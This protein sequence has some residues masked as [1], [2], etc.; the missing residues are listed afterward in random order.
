MERLWVFNPHIQSSILCNKKKNNQP[1]LYH[2]YP[3]L[4]T[5]LCSLSLPP[6]QPTYSIMS[7]LSILLFVIAS[8]TCSFVL[9][10]S[11]LSTFPSLTISFNQ[12]TSILNPFPTTFVSE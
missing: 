2:S 5:P 6:P 1:P 9:T 7:F 4:S 8:A 12:A 11:T 3:S 10:H